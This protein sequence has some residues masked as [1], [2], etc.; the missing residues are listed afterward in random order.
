MSARDRFHLKKF[1]YHGQLSIV[2][3]D[4]GTGLP[5]LL[6]LL[7]LQT[8]GLSKAINT[9]QQHMVS[10]CQWYNYW[11]QKHN[12]SFDEELFESFQPG[13]PLLT[14]LQALDA[15][16]VDYPGFVIF[17]D[18][19]KKLT[20]DPWREDYRPEI[21]DRT[22]DVR[23]SCLTQF[24]LFLA[25]RYVSSRYTQLTSRE[26][27]MTLDSYRVR[28]H[29]AR[30]EACGRL[31]TRQGQP[32]SK[33]SEGQL[34]VRE[35]SLNAAEV[36]A[37]ALCSRPS[38]SK[39]DNPLN[40][41]QKHVDNKQKSVLQVRNHLIIRLLLHYGLRIGELLLL[42]TKS[43]VPYASGSGQAL[44]IT[45]Y[46]GA[47]DPRKVAPRLK[48][49]WSERLLE[50]ASEDIKLWELYVD[51][52]RGMPSPPHP[53]LLVNTR[54]NHGPLSM[55]AA[56]NVFD[57]LYRTLQQHFPGLCS[58]ELGGTLTALHAHMFRF[59]WATD[60][61]EA[62]VEQD[63]CDFETAKDRL[64]QLGGWSQTSP[65][66]QKYAARYISKSANAANLRRLKAQRRMSAQSQEKQMEPEYR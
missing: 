56:Q 47:G 18:S 16:H 8:W 11:Q 44:A 37:I 25:R 13:F 42:R 46:D 29:G 5:A 9:V 39:Q 3:S 48:N 61:F 55:R 62:L 41:W 24:L 10:V 23:L 15:A 59:T 30:R 40:P 22:R 52:L 19:G 57:D 53:F 2:V 28:F 43:L 45:T 6:P 31:N 7:Y 26:Q 33:G 35:R 32:F 66:P 1:S 49:A 4:T 58:V 14:P 65:M 60:T 50:L 36:K 27:K 63:G 34:V 17:I 38:T 54:K 21:A 51:H 12:R 64:R 20:D